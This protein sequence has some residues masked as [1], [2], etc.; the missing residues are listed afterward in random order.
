MHG[1]NTKKLPVQL[2]LSQISKKL[3]FSFYLL[4][5]SPTKSEN[6]GQNRFC[7]VGVGVLEP[8]GGERRQGKW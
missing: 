3:R 6:R 8:V 7:G 1:N 5:F 2:S 4:F